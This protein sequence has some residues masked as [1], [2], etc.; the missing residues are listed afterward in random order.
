V[1][2]DLAP[3]YDLFETAVAAIRIHD[4][5]RSALALRAETFRDAL[6]VMGE[7]NVPPVPDQT[8]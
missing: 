3:L 6:L 7:T 4:Q 1:N 5:K 2:P 8:V